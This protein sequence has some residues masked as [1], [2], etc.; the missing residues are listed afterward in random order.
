MYVVEVVAEVKPISE[1]VVDKMLGLLVPLA[2]MAA[3]ALEPI[4]EM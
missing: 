4:S 3:L 2:I 1:I